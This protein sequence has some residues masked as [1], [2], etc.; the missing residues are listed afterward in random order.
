MRHRTPALAALAVILAGGTPAA[1][2][3]PGIEEAVGPSTGTPP[4]VLP[5][6]DGVRTSSLLTVGDAVE[7]YRMVGIPDGLGAY[8]VDGNSFTL[9]MNHEL[10]DQ[11]GIVRRHGQIGAF[12]SEWSIDR[13]SFEVEAGRDLIDPGVRVL[14]LHRGRLLARPSIGFGAAFDRFCSNTLSEPGQLFNAET[15]RGYEG[16]LFFPGE[17]NGDIGRGF[18]LTT[19]GQI[20]Q[21]P[22]LG[23][24]SYENSVPAHNRS[25][26]TLVVGNEDGDPGQLWIYSGTKQSTG[27]PFD[28]AGLTNGIPS[29]AAVAG[30]TTDAGFRAVYGEG[31]AGPL[32]AQPDRLDQ[33]DGPAQNAEAAA[34]GLG[35]NR[36]EDGHWDPANPNDFYFV[37]T[38]GGGAPT[39]RPAASAATAAAS[40]GSRSTTSSGRNSAAR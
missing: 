34:E 25:D 6:A 14:G 12:V 20:E 18:A 26:T 32:H 3:K 40:G 9:L 35:L 24:F 17:E 10:N 5:V 37:T 19:G 31:H 2:E 7:Q 36:I 21:L 11:S 29:V 23:L 39:P 33:G 15:G 8:R 4:Y 38:E 13:K 27:S 16:Q 22:R 30:A 1:A 28:R